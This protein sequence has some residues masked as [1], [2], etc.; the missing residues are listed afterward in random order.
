MLEDQPDRLLLDLRGI[1]HRC[2]H[3]SILSKFGVSGNPGAVQDWVRATGSEMSQ[4]TA[5]LDLMNTLEDV[6]RSSLGRYKA[7]LIILV[8]LDHSDIL[9]MAA[10]DLFG[11][12]TFHVLGFFLLPLLIDRAYLSGAFIA[13]RFVRYYVPFLAVLALSSALYWAFIRGQGNALQAASSLLLA[14][15]L[16]SAP[17]V[18]SA[19]GFLALWFLPALLGMAVVSAAF[20][21]ATP[22]SRLGLA[23]FFLFTHLV[24]VA[25]NAPWY[26]WIPLGLA[27]VANTFVL[28]LFAWRVARSTWCYRFRWIFPLV[29]LVSYGLLVRGGTRLEIA[30]L[31][32]ADVRSI[33]TLLLQD[34]VGVTG[35]VGVIIMA[36]LIRPWRWVEAIGE[37]SLW[38]YLIH[39]F[40]YIALARIGAFDGLGTLSRVELVAIGIF[41]AGAVISVAFVGSLSIQRSPAL[42]S[43]ISPRYWRDWAPVTLRRGAPL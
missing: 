6:L 18:K 4:P 11:P 24:M 36:G 37:H 27:I 8:V 10:P 38:I 9:R 43:W 17:F 1:P 5:R 28:A 2:A 7:L 40:L 13:D 19:S 12:L 39:P 32:L 20:R 33:R 15:V 23:S 31:T 29:F 35:V 42:K 16:G 26:R 22:R 30:D 25:A 21:M 41:V 3:D 34:A 14:A